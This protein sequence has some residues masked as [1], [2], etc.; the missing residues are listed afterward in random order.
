[1]TSKKYNVVAV[2]TGDPNKLP[3]W[4]GYLKTYME[5]K[6]S[7][8]G[9]VSMP[10]VLPPV[11]RSFEKLF[12]AIKAEKPDMVTFTPHEDW[13]NESLLSLCAELKAWNKDL[14]IVICAENP[15]NRMQVEAAE[16]SR[17]IDYLIHGEAE[18]PLEKLVE[19]CSGTAEVL[20]DFANLI[21]L[22]K[23]RKPAAA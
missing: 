2:G 9:R 1:M 5:Q 23:T 11:S 13:N 14:P 8:K 19:Y 21:C 7:M 10:I 4:V 16:R 17:S 22:T 18:A 6:S 12:E 3:V 20:P 15:R